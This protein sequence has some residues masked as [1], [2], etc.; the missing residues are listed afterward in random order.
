MGIACSSAKLM[1]ANT[2]Y[3]EEMSY[4]T[5]VSTLRQFS[6]S[7]LQVGFLRVHVVVEYTSLIEHTFLQ[8]CLLLCLEY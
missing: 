5:D 6:Q 8:M 1:L 3:S 2:G 7:N 4:L